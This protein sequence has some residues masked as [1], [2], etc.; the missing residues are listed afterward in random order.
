MLRNGINCIKFYWFGIFCTSI[1]GIVVSTF[2]DYR[3]LFSKGDFYIWRVS[4]TILVISVT[5]SDIIMLQVTALSRFLYLRIRYSIKCPLCIFPFLINSVDGKL[6]VKIGKKPEVVYCDFIDDEEYNRF[7][8]EEMIRILREGII[9]RKIGRYIF[10]ISV[11]ILF[12]CFKPA[13]ALIVIILFAEFEALDMIYER[14]F[15]GDNFKLRNIRR[16]NGALYLNKV[17]DDCR[18]ENFYD[19]DINK[20][21]VLG[22]VKRRLAKNIYDND[23]TEPAYVNNILKRLFMEPEEISTSPDIKE[24][25]IVTLYVFYALFSKNEDYVGNIRNVVL[26]MKL[27][28]GQY[29]KLWRDYFDYFLQIIDSYQWKKELKIN[30]KKDMILLYDCWANIPGKYRNTLLYVKNKID[31]YIKTLYVGF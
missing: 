9:A 6:E 10:G 3:V 5:V 2:L 14:K 1:M 27:Y 29:S 26:R 19:D 7:S 17:Y 25:D 23:Y 15:H 28:V 11:M 8:Y 18:V 12:L 20:N 31:D 24:L 4:F 30:K 13:G 16:G 21:Y 22:M